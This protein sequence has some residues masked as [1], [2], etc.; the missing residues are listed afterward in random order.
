MLLK[1]A[2]VVRVGVKSSGPPWT[3]C[4]FQGAPMF[5]EGAPAGQAECFLALLTAQRSSALAMCLGTALFCA[6][7]P[8]GGMGSQ[9]QSLATGAPSRLRCSVVAVAGYA[10]MDS[11]SDS[12]T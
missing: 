5:L 3:G 1:L 9:G 8:G 6:G 11:Q 12:W 10:I 7:G 2:P 4:D